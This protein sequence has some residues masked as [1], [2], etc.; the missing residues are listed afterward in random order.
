LVGGGTVRLVLTALFLVL[1]AWYLTSAAITLSNG[2]SGHGA[3]ALGSALHVLMSGAMISMFWPWGAGIPVIAQVTVFTAGAGWF[4]GQ[5]VFGT[6][7][8]GAGCYGDWYHAGMMA[9]MVWM[10]FTIAVM[11]P[12]AADGGTSG[13]SM[14]PMSMPG[15]DMGGQAQGGRPAGIV[16][17]GAPGWTGTVSLVLAAALFAATAWQAVATLRPLAVA[18]RALAPGQPRPGTES[19]VLRD[20]VGALMAAGMAVAL[21]LMA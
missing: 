18:E 16:M 11:S 8:H 4:A 3:R 14:A 2:G 5:A 7:H 6:G 1:G 12:S 20:G 9:V 15:M 21:L 10:A 13:M 17:A 19:T